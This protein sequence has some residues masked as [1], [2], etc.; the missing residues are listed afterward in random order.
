MKGSGRNVVEATMTVQQKEE[1]KKMGPSMA[2]KV[3]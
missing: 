1:M 3:L 2:G